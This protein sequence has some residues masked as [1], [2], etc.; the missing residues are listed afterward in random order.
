M[1]TGYSNLRMNLKRIRSLSKSVV[2]LGSGQ[3]LST[4]LYNQ[5][6]KADNVASSPAFFFFYNLLYCYLYCIVFISKG[7]YWS[8]PWMFCLF[9]FFFF[10][11][12][13]GKKHESKSLPSL[14]KPL[15]FDMC[16]F[17]LSI[18]LADYLSLSAGNVLPVFVSIWLT[19]FLYFCSLSLLAVAVSSLRFCQC[20]Q[21]C[22][23][24]HH[25]RLTVL[26]HTFYSCMY[27]SSNLC[28]AV[29]D[30]KWH[31]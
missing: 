26:C 4:H 23:L 17:L 3:A 11:W 6:E 25:K 13:C 16:L 29:C 28:F 2:I 5:E 9:A 22:F 14:L 8:F 10:F 15:R 20:F 31:A 19:V 1:K 21:E 30:N 27:P 12:W 18:K 24:P 7:E